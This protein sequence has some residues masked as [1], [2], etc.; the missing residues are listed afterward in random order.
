MQS[1]KKRNKYWLI[2]KEE[3]ENRIK[4]KEPR[5]N[6]RSREGASEMGRGN[7][8]SRKRRERTRGKERNAKKSGVA[9]GE[10]NERRAERSKTEG[11]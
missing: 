11:E 1:V 10:S 7:G 2:G 5:A 6:G 9:A 8:E 3:A 4:S